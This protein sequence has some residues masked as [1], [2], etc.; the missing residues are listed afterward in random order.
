MTDILV[1]DFVTVR[2]VTRRCHDENVPVI[3]SGIK[4]LPG[5]S[6]MQSWMEALVLCGNSHLCNK[7][8]LHFQHVGEDKLQQPDVDLM[9][10]F[11]SVLLSQRPMLKQKL[12][13]SVYQAKELDIPTMLMRDFFFT[14]YT[15]VRPAIIS[16]DVEDIDEFITANSAT[17]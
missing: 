10:A 16:D 9:K 6:E 12:V 1:A 2:V 11:V 8:I 15:P 5:I 17:L 7:F 4:R 3:W 14:L 13:C